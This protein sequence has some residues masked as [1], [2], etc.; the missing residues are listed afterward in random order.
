M[1]RISFSLPRYEYAIN[2]LR[3]EVLFGLHMEDEILKLFPPIEM[4][5]R[6]TTRLVSKPTILDRSTRPHK[7]KVSMDEAMF[8]QTDVIKCTDVISQLTMSLLNQQK[9]HTFE[10]MFET[11][12]A[13]GNSI[14]GK[15]RG[16]WE[17]YIEALQKLDYRFEGYKCYVGSDVMEKMLASPPTEEQ[18]SRAKEVVKAKRE[19]AL[20]KKRVRRLK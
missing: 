18:L 6:G 4:F 19:E 20:T 13:A 10:V 8:L 16:V 3:D 9:A 17:L 1:S 2:K 12:E 14:D 5:H 15:G 11:G 7:S